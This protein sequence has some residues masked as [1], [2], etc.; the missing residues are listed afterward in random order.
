MSLR[1]YLARLGET[2]L[3]PEERAERAAVAGQILREWSGYDPAAVD[4]PRLD[5]VLEQRIA[6][7]TG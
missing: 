4:Q 2:L 6:K 3:T 5:E 7:A 1:G